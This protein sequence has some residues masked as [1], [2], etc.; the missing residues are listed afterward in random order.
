MKLDSTL[1]AFDSQCLEAQLSSEGSMGLYFP[2]HEA[3]RPEHRATHPHIEKIARNYLTRQKMKSV[4]T[5]SN[6][7]PTLLPSPLTEWLVPYAQTIAHDCFA[8]FAF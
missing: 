1:D 2:I 5:Q 8:L 6:P 4:E 7:L 3:F